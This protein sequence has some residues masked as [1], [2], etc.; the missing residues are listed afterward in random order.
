MSTWNDELWQLLEALCED[1]INADELLRLE[2]IVLSSKEAKL[3]YIRYI[4]LHG[5]LYWNAA[6]GARQ[7]EVSPVADEDSVSDKDPV[8]DKDFARAAVP[9]TEVDRDSEFKESPAELT[10]EQ[11]SSLMV[12]S[13][14]ENEPLV[15]LSTDQEVALP[16][17]KE[18]LG[19]EGYL[20]QELPSRLTAVKALATASQLS[21]AG[22]STHGS[23]SW[24]SGMSG[25]SKSR[26]S[27]RLNK[28]LKSTGSAYAGIAAVLLVC[29]SI[30]SWQQIRGHSGQF[31]ASLWKPAANLD[32]PLANHAD[33]S[34]SVPAGSLT[35]VDTTA[36]P[37]AEINGP[38]NRSESE[39][40]ARTN[41][42]TPVALPLSVLDN[43]QGISQTSPTEERIAQRAQALKE[44]QAMAEEAA[45]IK[46]L[47]ES[48]S[49]FVKSPSK[50]SIALTYPQGRLSSAQVVSQVND[51]LTKTWKE[52][53]L[54]P[55]PLA[56]EAEW[57]RRVYLDLVGHI[58][59]SA[60]TE[61]YLSDRS[62]G[63]RE[64]LVDRLLDDPGFARHL[65]TT[66]TN[67]LVGRHG[68]ET[69]DRQ[70]L[71][72][73]LRV[74]FA[75]HRPWNRI[76]EEL[77]SASGRSHEN[78][79]TNFLLANLNQDASAATTRT[80]RLFLGQSLDCVQCHQHPFDDARQAKFWE[81]NSFFRQA[82]SR[83]VLVLDQQTGKRVQV[84]HELYDLPV[85]GPV[86]FETTNQTSVAAFPRWAGQEVD[87]SATTR[88]RVE[89]GRI[90]AEDH[91][92]QLARAFVNR[93]WSQFFGRGFTTPVD[94]MGVH[95][96]PVHPELLELL[97]RS[98]VQENYSIR[99]LVRCLV[100][101]RPYQLASIVD[102]DS[103][104]K[105]LPNATGSESVIR[106][107]YTSFEFMRARPLSPEQIFDSFLIMKSPVPGQQ[108]FWMEAIEKRQEWIAPFIQQLPT[109]ENIETSLYASPLQEVLT[110]MNGDLTQD[111]LTAA[112]GTLLAETLKRY[113]RDVDRANALT[114]AI[115]S[116][117]AT[118]TELT[119]L[120]AALSKVAGQVK[121]GE[122]A[123]MLT[124]DL[125]RDFAWAL[126]NSSE[127][128]MNH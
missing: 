41:G 101:S 17:T 1:R 107:D 62:P 19:P 14:P 4:D 61:A 95:Q 34:A 116:R 60:E 46:S 36:P 72:E 81:L 21:P 38:L 85:A 126:L 68:L 58:P 99:E 20:W 91:D 66:W 33:L 92:H 70:A 51:Y 103:A 32:S 73:Y 96:P 39:T 50:P 48:V 109:E 24:L 63:R 23:T 128:R 8:A 26:R 25:K 74:S 5:S 77:V 65:A 83:P 45:R 47:S 2:Q 102:F 55:A 13:I 27:R 37:A 97:T 118:E 89:L 104:P 35:K 31:L 59:T 100:N 11:F 76:V 123:E 115:V 28:W 69:A 90:L 53:N 88:R 67:L 80:A 110:L 54:T 122:N 78:G 29:L 56:S 86:Y 98:F 84:A 30:A 105:S 6:F 79:A 75:G 15:S 3:F 93:Q 22:K 44:Q 108:Q 10:W 71:H 113:P 57:H 43:P 111:L 121:N 87:D 117:K 125:W 7:D 94:D 82:S 114:M 16:E 106:E 52:E 124:L 127:F 40:T 49:A 64:R 112:S 120:R 9:D 42:R 12:E 18:A 119:L